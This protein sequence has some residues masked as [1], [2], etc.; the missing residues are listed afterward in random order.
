MHVLGTSGVMVSPERAESLQRHVHRALLTLRSSLSIE[1]RAEARL[2]P[3]KLLAIQVNSASSIPTLDLPHHGRQAP[4]ILPTEEEKGKII[5]SWMEG[6]R[7]MT[8]QLGPWSPPGEGGGERSTAST[9]DSPSC[10]P[11]QGCPGATCPTTPSYLRMC[12]CRSKFLVN[13][14]SQ[15]EHLSF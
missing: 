6:L 2:P 5:L 9:V 4:Q 7:T 10:L 15:Y 1:V 3:A 8:D 11:A 14:L 12:C 13:D